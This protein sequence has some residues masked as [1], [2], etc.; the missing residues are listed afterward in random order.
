MGLG[1]TGVCSIDDAITVI[2]RRRIGLHDR[3]L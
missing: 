3:R 1:Q 2:A